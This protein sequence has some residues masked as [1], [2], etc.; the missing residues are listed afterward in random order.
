MGLQVTPH[1][2]EVYASP[3]VKRTVT[4]V[5]DTVY[6]GASAAVS[7]T[8]YD[9]TLTSGQSMDHET[10]RWFVTAADIGGGFAGSARLEVEDRDEEEEF[11]HRRIIAED[12]DDLAAQV[13]RLRTGLTYTY[14]LIDADGVWLD[15]GTGVR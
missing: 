4:A 3:D 14:Q 11:S 8:S 13:A 9:G 5:G 15:S 12:D 2:I 10:T 7:S 1:P 6:Y